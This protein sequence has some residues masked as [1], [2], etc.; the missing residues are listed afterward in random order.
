[1]HFILVYVN[2]MNSILLQYIYVT[3]ARCN[4]NDS[5][6]KPIFVYNTFKIDQYLL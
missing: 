2:V 1:M 6:T 4:M 5:W 3:C